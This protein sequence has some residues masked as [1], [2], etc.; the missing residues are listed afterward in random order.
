MIEMN[1]LN[2]KVAELLLAS[3][4][5][6]DRSVDVGGIVTILENEGFQSS[7]TAFELLAS[8]NGL[9]VETAKH[10]ILPYVYVFNPI[11][12]ASGEYD[13]VLAW[14]KQLNIDLFPLGREVHNGSVVWYG[15]DGKFYFGF[16]FGLYHIGDAIDDALSRLFL[17]E[18]EIMQCAD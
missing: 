1:D 5:H 12:A 8:L 9:R 4:W 11:D 16:E 2:P 13:R 7:S 10:T 6:Q 18:G 15:S 14:K 17:C 3:G